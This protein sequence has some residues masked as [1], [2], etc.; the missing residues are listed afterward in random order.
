MTTRTRTNWKLDNQGQFARQI[1]WKRARGG[2]RTQHKFRLGANLKEAKRREQK[3]QEFWEWIDERRAPSAAWDPFTLMV[4]KQIAKGTVQIPIPRKRNDGPEAYARYVHRVQRNYPMISFVVEDEEAYIAGAGKNR[5]MF[6]GQIEKL[7][8][9]IAKKR[10][11]HQRIGN[12]GEIDA[13]AAGETLQEAMRAYIEW[14]Q[15]DYFRPALNRITPNGHTKIRQVQ[16]LIERYDNIPLSKLGNDSVEQMFR[17]FRRRPYRKGTTKQI[18]KKS[19][20]NY[21]AELKRFFRWL[22]KS[23]EFDWRKPDDFD[24]INTRVDDDR[25]GQQA[26]L[27]QVDTFSLEELRLLNKYA[28]PLERLFLLLGINCGFGAAEIA[29]LLIGEVILFQGHEERH[30]EILGVRTTNADS[31]IK[32]IRRKNGVYGEFALFPQTVVAMQW[33]LHRRHLQPEST[34]G[35]VLLLND[36]GEAYNTPTIS[37]NRNQQIPNRFADLIRR[38]RIDYS[39]FPKFSF[40]KLRKTAGDLVR[41]FSD[42]EIHSVFM[43]HGQPVATDDL[44]DIYSNRPIGKVFQAIGVVQEYLQPVFEAAG[45]NPFDRQAQAY[46]SIKTRDRILELHEEGESIRAI[47]AE[48]KKSRSTIHRHLKRFK[49]V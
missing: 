16:T 48:V 22:H 41:R 13:T 8:E 29:S 37:G 6:Q 27:A 11:V 31:F 3:L 39:D 45:P 33:A 15:T 26:K 38:I 23:S 30:Q 20:Q 25:E 49:Q 24:E 4:A 9:E 47:A 12:V 42:G 43:C 21:I 35:P 44:T 1:G 18:T 7:E 19:A 32:R 2:K 10:G 28:T 46:T 14:I 40:G 34:H 17:Y 36:N 5:L